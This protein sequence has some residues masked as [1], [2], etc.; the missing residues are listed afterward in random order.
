MQNK[1]TLE[2]LR[3]KIDD[4]DEQLFLLLKSRLEIVEKVG[5]LKKSNNSEKYIIRAGREAQKVQ[6]IFELA[7]N[8]G[9]NN[10]ISTAFACIWR[11]IIS[12]SINHE[13]PALIAYNPSSDPTILWKLRE[14]MGCYSDKLIC[15][16]DIN[17]I[18]ALTQ[19]KANIA[20]F[21]LQKNYSS[22]PWWLELVNYPEFSVFTNIPLYTS[23]LNNENVFLVS[24]VS[25][26]PIGKDRFLYVTSSEIPFNEVDNFET[27]SEYKNYKLVICEEF[28][29]NYQSKLKANYIG[30]YSIIE[31]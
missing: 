15:K 7:K 19:K 30:C 28:Y 11:E 12:L 9:F 4:L 25:P 17:C 21:N 13:E 1:E 16:S 23:G 10:K 31:D 18:E 20:A 27:I 14:Y 24:A 2:D 22:N 3:K 6:K 8:S 26:E 5:H 29:N